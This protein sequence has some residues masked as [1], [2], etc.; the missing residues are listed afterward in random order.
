MRQTS[1]ALQ[2]PT[3]A[4]QQTTLASRRRYLVPAVALGLVLAA[5]LAA[6]RLFN[7]QRSAPVVAGK[8]TQRPD[9][10]KQGSP[11]VATRQTPVQ[12]EAGPPALTASSIVPGKVVHQVLPDVPRSARNTIQG[13]IK[14][15]VRVRVDPSGNVAGVKL[16][17]PGP[18]RYFAELALK[19]ARRWKFEPARVDDRNV[20]SEWILRFEFGKTGTNV[21]S[22]LAP[23]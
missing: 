6:P 14:V 19:A 22:V 16:A 7:R 8:S 3:S 12:S 5:V 9:D 4:I 17:S 13:K 10:K 2:G 20:S 1:P 18:S 15:G 23:A 21:F 11:Q